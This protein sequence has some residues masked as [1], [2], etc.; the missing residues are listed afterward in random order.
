MPSPNL[1]HPIPVVVEAL[2]R[3]ATVV[4]EDYR[5]PYQNAARGAKTT[6]NGQISWVIEDKLKASLEGALREAEG[7][8]LF[9]TSDL[10]AASVTMGQGARFL[11]FGTGA[12]KVDVDLYVI[13]IQ[14]TGHYGDQG[15]ATLIRAYFQDRTPSKQNRGGL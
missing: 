8:V 4:D 6:V 15:G 12:N 1:I 10:R 13:G 3:S 11:S 7:Y 5:E 9:R 14:Y 2:N